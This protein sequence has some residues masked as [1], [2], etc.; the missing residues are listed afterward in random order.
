MRSMAMQ[1]KKTNRIKKYWNPKEKT[2]RTET[3]WEIIKL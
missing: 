2:V 3:F 1:E